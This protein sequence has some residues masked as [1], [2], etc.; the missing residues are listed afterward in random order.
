MRVLEALSESFG[1]TVGG[2]R[3]RKATRG[4]DIRSATN[5]LG[6]RNAL[7]KPWIMSVARRKEG[8]LIPS[9]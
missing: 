7:E 5:N 2:L 3:R 8:V 6:P 4:A 9:L 1:T